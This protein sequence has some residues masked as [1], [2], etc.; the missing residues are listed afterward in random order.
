[1]RWLFESKLVFTIAL[2]TSLAPAA[3]RALYV[4]RSLNTAAVA[5]DV[6][7]CVQEKY[8]AIDSR[9]S[10]LVPVWPVQ[11]A[12]IAKQDPVPVNNSFWAVFSLAAKEFG[13]NPDVTRESWLQ[14]LKG[15]YIAPAKGFQSD[16]LNRFRLLAVVNRLDLAK[17]T[18]GPADSP[19]HW[20]GAELR[21]V[22]GRKHKN[23]Q[24]DPSFTLI[25]E[26][27]LPDTS[28]KEFQDQADQWSKLAGTTPATLQPAL[29]RVIDNSGYRS[30]Q[31]IRIR[32]N[33]KNVGS[34][35]L[36]AEWQ[37]QRQ[38]GAS[39]GGFGSTA[40]DFQTAAPFA[41]HLWPGGRADGSPI[42]VPPE[43]STKV[44]KYQSTG[45]ATFIPAPV[46]VADS[47]SSRMIR[48]TLALQQCTGCHSDETGT[49]L[50]HISDKGVLSSFLLTALKPSPGKI[51]DGKTA[52]NWNPTIVDLMDKSNPVTFSVTIHYCS[53][54]KEPASVT[55]MCDHDQQEIKETRLYHDMARRKLFMASVLA[56]SPTGPTPADI[57]NFNAYAP[58][59]IH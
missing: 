14:D 36:F 29:Q 41:T 57:N 47:D 1:M 22:F 40:L 6:P 8:T 53:P 33:A 13:L 7:K 3:D 46:G 12:E 54:N 59:F 19:G 31:C 20:T 48:N 56:A 43:L 37:F 11:D 4:G 52:L 28:W 39:Q 38:P 50:Q 2:L 21:F 42:P 34:Q 16:F 24:Q 25:V 35:W 55:G 15:T 32:S 58:T 9:R 30:A 5:T 45:G 27:V 44:V 51:G 26:F 23:I 49:S 10:L 18:E 17:W